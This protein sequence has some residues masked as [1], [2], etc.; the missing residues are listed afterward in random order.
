MENFGSTER[1]RGQ[2]GGVLTPLSSDTNWGSPHY[3]SGTG[4]CPDRGETPSRCYKLCYGLDLSA[5]AAAPTTSAPVQQIR[6]GGSVVNFDGAGVWEEHPNQHFQ[7]GC[8]YPSIG[9]FVSHNGQ[10]AAWCAQQCSQ[11]TDCTGFHVRGTNCQFCSDSLSNQQPRSLSGSD[12]Y[13]KLQTTVTGTGPTFTPT[14]LM[15]SQVPT[16]VP[17]EIPTPVP[18]VTPTEHPT[19]KPPSP[20]PSYT[21]TEVPTV[22]PTWTPTEHPTL[23]PSSSVNSCHCV[24]CNNHYWAT[25]HVPDT[26]ASCR[27]KCDADTHCKFALYRASTLSCFLYATPPSSQQEQTGKQQYMCYHK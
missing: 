21:P 11:A 20:S 18:S 14:T 9:G 5:P 6:S 24:G 16:P 2:V 25:S 12:L 4:G 27:Q 17:T 3:N 7:P 23:V 8:S 22:A 1:A 26:A 13:Y 15:P 19:T 10:G